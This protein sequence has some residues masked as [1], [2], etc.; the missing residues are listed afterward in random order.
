MKDKCLSLI[1]VWVARSEMG[2]VILKKGEITFYS[3]KTESLSTNFKS[4]KFGLFSEDKGS[5]TLFLGNLVC[6]IR[7]PMF[8]S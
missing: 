2:S 4:I 7:K 8:A 1:F 6:L 5:D 3:Q